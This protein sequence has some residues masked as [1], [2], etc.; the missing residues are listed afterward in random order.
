ML[1]GCSHV[2]LLKA[3]KQNTQYSFYMNLSIPHQLNIVIII[4]QLHIFIAFLIK[5]MWIAD[6]LMESFQLCLM[7]KAHLQHQMKAQRLLFRT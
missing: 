7:A 3:L 4:Q 5:K 1:E 2:A 6:L